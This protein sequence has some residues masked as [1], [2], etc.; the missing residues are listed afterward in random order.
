MVAPATVWLKPREGLTPLWAVQL[1][2]PPLRL[3]RTRAQQ[4]KERRREKYR[5]EPSAKLNVLR[6]NEVSFFYR[7]AASQFINTYFLLKV[8]GVYQSTIKNYVSHFYD[9]KRIFN[10][11]E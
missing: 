4:Q 3:P 9:K 11:L 6:N 1:S 7:N 5:A 2:L 8:Y 10:F